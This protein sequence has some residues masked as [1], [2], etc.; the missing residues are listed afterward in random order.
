MWVPQLYDDERDGEHCGGREE[1]DRAHRRP[2][3]FGRGQ[4]GVHQEEQ[5]QGGAQRA[6]EVEVR[7]LEPG[8]HRCSGYGADSDDEQRQ[9]ERSGKQQRR[10]PGEL[11]EQPAEDQTE[12]KT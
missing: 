4:D 9:R 10:S 3:G 12:R 6:E 7:E 11:G 2:P 5:R 1:R 8:A